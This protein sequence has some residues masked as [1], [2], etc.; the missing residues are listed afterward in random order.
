MEHETAKTVRL[1][2]HSS[3]GSS[4]S[5]LHEFKAG[6]SDDL[7]E[8]APHIIFTPYIRTLAAELSKG[9]E[10]PLEKARSFYDFITLNFKYT[11]MPAYFSLEDIPG[12]CARTFTG[13]C[14]VF[15]LL[16]ITL[17]R[18]AGIPAQWQS[19]L[20]A[21]PDFIGGHDWVRFYAAPLGWIYAD[22]SYGIGAVR[23]ENEERRRFYFGNLDPYRMVAN[24]AFQAPFTVE[25]K[26]WR[27]DPYDNQLGEIETAER[28]LR[29]E[30][31][32]RRKDVLMCEEIEE[33]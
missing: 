21:E 15:A 33:N 11:Y 3:N 23:A 22:P 13:D 9:C 29:Y 32:E 30:E 1:Y 16:F 17:C 28:G 2:G 20:A 31:F 12:N 6:V 14:G 4:A 7:S 27:T 19:G 18:C 25:K 8:L 5:S 26:Y 24:R 10:T